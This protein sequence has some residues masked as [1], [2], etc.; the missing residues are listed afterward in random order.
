MTMTRVFDTSTEPTNRTKVQ[1]NVDK[2]NQ[3]K[4]ET[5]F[6]AW[7]DLR[8]RGFKVRDVASYESLLHDCC[9]GSA[10]KGTLTLVRT[11]HEH[12]GRCRRTLQHR[13]DVMVSFGVACR[14]AAQTHAQAA[15]TMDCDE[16]EKAHGRQGLACVASCN[17]PAQALGDHHQI[18]YIQMY[19]SLAWSYVPVMVACSSAWHRIACCR[20]AYNA[21]EKKEHAVGR[22]Q[23]LVGHGTAGQGW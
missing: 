20:Q 14:S 4:R 13:F 2:N 23:T 21:Q 9:G 1:R 6:V 19:W 5:A 17:T 10:P 12:D 11:G 22:F 7:Q 18:H 15:V 16:A 8:S 3:I